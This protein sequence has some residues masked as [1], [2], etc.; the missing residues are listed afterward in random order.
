MAKNKKVKDKQQGNFDIE[1]YLESLIEKVNGKLGKSKTD[2]E[3]YWI[4]EDL[5]STIDNDLRKVDSMVSVSINWRG[6]EVNDLVLESI[7]IE[8]SEA[9]QREKGLPP[10][11]NVDI[12]SR[13]F[14]EMLGG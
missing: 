14:K 5:S 2:I 3:K 9:A 13:V 4:V 1:T 11:T 10:T 6:E 8:W 7:S 12:M